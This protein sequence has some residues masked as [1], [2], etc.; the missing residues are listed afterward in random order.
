MFEN[1]TITGT[2][3]GGNH[4][5]VTATVA[6]VE[7]QYVLSKADVLTDD[8]QIT[9]RTEQQAL[10]RAIIRHAKANGITKFSDLKDSISNLSL[11]A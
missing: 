4:V 8:G 2:C 10:V 6:R 9:P 3:P 5:F 7:R 11:A 1:V